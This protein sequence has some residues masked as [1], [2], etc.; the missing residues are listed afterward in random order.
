M[1]KLQAGGQMRR[2]QLLREQVGEAIKKRGAAPGMHKTRWGYAW[3]S[4]DLGPENKPQNG[5]GTC[6]S[7]E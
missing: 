5:T 6:K 4:T 1:V 2:K 3:I 7:L